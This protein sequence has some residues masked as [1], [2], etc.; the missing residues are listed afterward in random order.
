MPFF[1]PYFSGKTFFNSTLSITKSKARF[2]FILPLKLIGALLTYPTAFEILIVLFEKSIS[3][4][5]FLTLSPEELITPSDI[6]IKPEDF[7]L[8]KSPLIVKSAS[9]VPSIELMPLNLEQ[10]TNNLTFLYISLK[11]I[12]SVF[13]FISI[14]GFLE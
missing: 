5:I 13:T 11:D 8:F 14:S 6:F 7:S 9:I 2:L 4:V 3:D 12:L 1:T 10:S